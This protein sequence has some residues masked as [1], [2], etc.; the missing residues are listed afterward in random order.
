[1]SWFASTTRVPAAGTASGD[2][3]EAASL[4][5]ETAVDAVTDAELPGTI[6]SAVPASS[7]RAEPPRAMSL[8]CRK[9]RMRVPDIGTSTLIALGR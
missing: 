2:E 3:G 6:A 5:R 1:M 7:A 8:P 9:E 4:T